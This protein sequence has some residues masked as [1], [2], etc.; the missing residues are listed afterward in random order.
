MPAQ[1]GLGRQRNRARADR[2]PV[3]A[4]FLTGLLDLDEHA[5]RPFA[6]QRRAAP[7]QR[8][9]ALDRLDPEHE[10]LLH[11]DRLAD[12]E[13]AER[14]GDAQPALDIGLRL[15]VRAEAAETALPARGPASSS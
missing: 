3:G 4:A 7:Q 5:A 12:I 10:A 9:G 11:D 14:P 15:R 2:R 6:P 13:R 1:P 8:V